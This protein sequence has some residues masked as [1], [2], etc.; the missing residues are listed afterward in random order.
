MP[1]L[2]KPEGRALDIAVVGLGQ[3]GGNLAAE[4]HR[5]GYPALALNTARTDLTA[6]G[7][8][9]VF[10]SLPEDR[11]IYIGI[12]GYDG[13][14]A[15]P[16]YG[17]DC[18]QAHAETI[19]TAVLD[20]AGD[21]DAILITAGLGGG[22]GSSIASLV[23]VLQIDELPMFAMM[24][25]PKEGES[26]IA[27]VNAV[28]AINEIVETQLLSWVFVDNARLGKLN[29]DLAVMDY[30]AKINE[31]IAAPLDALNCLNDRPHMQAI[32]AFDGEDF[33]KLLL[34]G[35]ILNYAVV[36][37]PKISA[38]VVLNAFRDAIERSEIMP[39]GF[40]MDQLS[41]VGTVIEADDRT[42]AETPISVFE[43]IDD[44]IKELTGGAATYAGLYRT[45]GGSGATL[46]ILATSQTLPHRMRELLTA[47]RK[48][49]GIIGQ[50][51]QEEL[52]T[53]ELG[54]IDNFELFRTN[55]HPGNKLQR[56]PRRTLTPAAAGL[57]SL[58]LPRKIGSAAAAVG[59]R[60]PLQRTP[61]APVPD[62]RGQRV[63]PAT[64]PRAGR[65]RA[66]GPNTGGERR[67][68]TGD[69]PKTDDD[70][71]GAGVPQPQPNQPA[72]RTS[73]EPVV[74]P[75]K[76]AAS[77]NEPPPPQEAIGLDDDQE[78]PVGLIVSGEI[79]PETYDRLVSE[80]LTAESADE[81][82]AV[83]TRLESDVRSAHPKVRYYA[84]EAMSK[85][86]VEQFPKAF[87]RALTDP[88][89]D[90]RHLASQVAAAR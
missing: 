7:P 53:L 88:D 42:L 47:A 90:V 45:E 55:T 62:R 71:G 29:A 60:A 14:G 5:L 63:P 40:E 19:R 84:L 80:F 15:D 65:V 58:D 11:R 34:S 83:A 75:S 16:R 12:D 30:Y 46:R 6:L 38:D 50:K 10:P 81:R 56:G 31:H 27:K 66:S 23:K 61:Q 44:Q 39:S 1:P 85:L 87:E 17:Q 70:D 37:L 68:R 77:T 54:E 78:T 43:E 59:R 69:L 21:A 32:R 35:G 3:A 2:V 72:A 36:E 26:G 13:A 41:Y 82:G 52:P 49:G 24:T 57:A 76:M 51:I 22:T 33:R 25:L 8:D 74:R 9:G 86:G 4:F 48:E 73:T 64:T 89:E 18:V 20:L 28:R 79:N 67:P